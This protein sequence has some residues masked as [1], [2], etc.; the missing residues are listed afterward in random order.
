[1]NKRIK[2]LAL[3]AGFVFTNDGQTIDWSSNYDAELETLVKAVEQNAFKQ[4]AEAEMIIAD[5]QL[6]LEKLIEK[7]ESEAAFKPERCY[8]AS[9]KQAIKI[10][11]LQNAI[12]K[13]GAHLSDCNIEAENECSCGY[14]ELDIEIRAAGE[15]K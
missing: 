12:L 2:E 15:I 7:N 9:N 6:Q 8:L 10:E 1:M 11:E 4:K 13:Y 14:F 3:Q 5:L